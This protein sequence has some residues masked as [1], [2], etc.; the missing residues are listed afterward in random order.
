MRAREE[1]RLA[2]RRHRL[3]GHHAVERLLDG[4]PCEANRPDGVPARPSGGPP[5]RKPARVSWKG[6]CPSARAAARS[7]SVRRAVIIKNRASPPHANL[8]Q[9]ELRLRAERSPR[10]ACITGSSS[11]GLKKDRDGLLGRR[12]EAPRT[13]RSRSL[14]GRPAVDA[15]DVLAEDRSPARSALDLADVSPPCLAA[16]ARGRVLLQPATRPRRE[17]LVL[18]RS[19]VSLESFLVARGAC[20][21][22]RVYLLAPRSR[23]SPRARASKTDGGRR[24]PRIARGP[25]AARTPGAARCRGAR[26]LATGRA[27]ARRNLSPKSGSHVVKSLARPRRSVSAAARDQKR[28]GSRVPPSGAMQSTRASRT[29]VQ[30]L[31]DLGRIAAVVTPT[32]S[33]R[34]V[35]SSGS[36]PSPRQAPSCHGRRPEIHIQDAAPDDAALVVAVRP[37]PSANYRTARAD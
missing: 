1:E 24:Q 13:R 7:R 29:H 14:R 20:G 8:E 26:R 15:A 36:K 9:C 23:T 16:P 11:R 35:V 22:R 10:P 25:R 19:R 33:R 32:G 30:W 2:C 27:R 21:P 6:T 12:V 17:Q 18:A 5:A 3:A 4:G 37:R 34:R 28:R 31:A